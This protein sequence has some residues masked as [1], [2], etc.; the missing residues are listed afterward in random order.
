MRAFASFLPAAATTEF[1]PDINLFP[2]SV[3]TQLANA[4]RGLRIKVGK[5]K[6]RGAS[7]AVERAK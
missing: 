2:A 6:E 4:V 7:A 1:G 5:Q 3:G